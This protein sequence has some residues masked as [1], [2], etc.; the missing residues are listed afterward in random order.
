VCHARQAVVVRRE[1]RELDIYAL[2]IAKP[3]AQLGARTGLSGN[4]SFELTYTAEPSADSDT[5]GL[6]TAI[7][8]QLGLKLEAT[9]GPVGVLVVERAQRPAPD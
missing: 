8:E 7:Q 5:P 1:T 9:T 3:A 4:W 2:T 6:F